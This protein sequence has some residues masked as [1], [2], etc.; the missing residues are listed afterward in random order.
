MCTCVMYVSWNF[1]KLLPL[2]NWIII[3][4]AKSVVGDAS[5]VY[6]CVCQHVCLCVST[7][8]FVYVNINVC[9]CQHVCVCVS[10]C[11]FVCVNM[12]VCVCQHVCLCVSLIILIHRHKIRLHNAIF[13]GYISDRFLSSVIFHYYWT[14]CSR[15]IQEMGEMKKF[16]H[17]YF[18]HSRLP[19]LH[20]IIHSHVL[21]DVS[22]LTIPSKKKPSRYYSN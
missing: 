14:N 13:L 10:T 17:S 5:Y 6:V 15:N 2:F 9:T 18:S 20:T 19:Q 22:H 16:A 7:C 1:T 12:Y 8:M 3:S 21:S 11:M 4:L